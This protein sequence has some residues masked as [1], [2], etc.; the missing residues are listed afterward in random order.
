MHTKNEIRTLLADLES[1][2]IERTGST[3]D[4][5]ENVSTKYFEAGF[6]N[7]ENKIIIQI[8]DE[9][10]PISEDTTLV[11]TP[12]GEDTTPIGNETTPI[13]T[14]ERIVAAI[15]DNPFITRSE[16]SEL[17]HITVDGVKY[18]LQTMRKKGKIQHIG[19][20][21]GGQWI[22]LSGLN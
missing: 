7:N 14:Q 10:T 1:S 16:L 5:V 15:K 11:T 22:I 21:R 12:I 20:N 4:V 19:T 6:G 13:T 9:T 18:Q 8:S 2:H 3:G 17:L